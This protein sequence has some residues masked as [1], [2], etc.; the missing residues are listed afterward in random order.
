M[1]T[2]LTA[3]ASLSPRLLVVS[4]NCREGL[5]V[6]LEAHVIRAYRS[7]RQALTSHRVASINSSNASNILLPHTAALVCSGDQ[8]STVPSGT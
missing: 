6:D 2:I 1:A 8:V 3:R 5:H 7:N 4:H